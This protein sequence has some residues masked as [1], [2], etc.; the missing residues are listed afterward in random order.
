MALALLLAAILAA[1]EW[2]LPKRG[3]AAVVLLLLLAPAAHA[4]P[5]ASSVLTYTTGLAL[6]GK[7]DAKARRPFPPSCWMRTRRY[8]PPL[9]TKSAM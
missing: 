4:V 6:E 8:R 9:S 1:T 5:D 7:D 2:R 3:A